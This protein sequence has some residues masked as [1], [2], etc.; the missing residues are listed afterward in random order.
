MPL[1]PLPTTTAE[2]VSR[3][4]NVPRGQNPPA[5]NGLR[6][7][8]SQGSNFIKPPGFLFAQGS[9]PVPFLPGIPSPLPPSTLPGLLHS[10]LPR[11]S[12]SSQSPACR[13]N[14][15]WPSH[16]G[17]VARNRGYITYGKCNT[18]NAFFKAKAQIQNTHGTPEAS[19]QKGVIA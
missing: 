13:P 16:P 6:G 3:L 10:R 2:N 8:C 4:R 11:A 14:T 18:F 1:A 5:E 7:A 17:G 19:L 15:R 9:R 12:C